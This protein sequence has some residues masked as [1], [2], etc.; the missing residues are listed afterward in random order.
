VREPEGRGSVCTIH[1]YGRINNTRKSCVRKFVHSD[2]LRR[3]Y[4][5][6]YV[7]VAIT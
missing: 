3:Q 5:S 7:V 2:G 4:L 6:A 1:T